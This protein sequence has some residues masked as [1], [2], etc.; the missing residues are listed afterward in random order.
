[1]EGGRG[2]LGGGGAGC[3]NVG[4][5]KT[6]GLGDVKG[7]VSFF[8]GE[9]KETSFRGDANTAISFLGVMIFWGEGAAETGRDVVS[10]L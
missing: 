7:T 3:D 8:G 10:L 9:A 2:S 4:K 6:E 1:M 5:V